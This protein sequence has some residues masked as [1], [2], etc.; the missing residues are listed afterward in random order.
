VVP[1][2]V[3]APSRACPGKGHAKLFLRR[4][5]Q[6]CAAPAAVAPGKAFAEG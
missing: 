6:S 1:D 2:G 4:S 3:V 5:P